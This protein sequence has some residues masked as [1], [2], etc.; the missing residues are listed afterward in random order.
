MEG[1]DERCSSVAQNLQIYSKVIGLGFYMSTLNSYSGSL[2]EPSE[3][4]T[5]KP[6]RKIRFCIY[7]TNIN[8][9]NFNSEAVT[10]LRPTWE[11]KVGKRFHGKAAGRN[12]FF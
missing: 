1:W 7:L 8:L 4:E 5:S 10:C 2:K 11:I 12:L 6:A 9:K 3:R